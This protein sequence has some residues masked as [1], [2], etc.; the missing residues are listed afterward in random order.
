MDFL[1]SG[2][3]HKRT[4][5]GTSTRSKLLRHDRAREAQVIWAALVG[6][7]LGA[8]ALYHLAGARAPRSSVTDTVRTPASDL[9]GR[10]TSPSP[11][12]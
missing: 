12:T 5:T 6:V 8:I 3:S 4:S 11:G 10:T 2:R 9:L 1:S 7:A